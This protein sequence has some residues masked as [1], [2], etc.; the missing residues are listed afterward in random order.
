[1]KQEFWTEK[2]TAAF[3]GV[4][5][6]TLAM[7][8]YFQR[9]PLAFV[10]TGVWVRYPRAEVLAFAR[11]YPVWR[12]MWTRPLPAA[13]WTEAQTAAFLGV[14]RGTLAMWRRERRYPLAYVKVGGAVRYAR[15]DVLA[16]GKVYGVLKRARLRRRRLNRDR[17]RQVR[18]LNARSMAAEDGKAP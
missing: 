7:R 5:Q 17:S 3:L 11:V 4:Q 18:G 8:R 14:R 12:K 2:Q 16:F 9:F 15:A 6:G 1:M 13:W 10:K